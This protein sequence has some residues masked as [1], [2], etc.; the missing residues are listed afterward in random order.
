LLIDYIINKV[1][2]FK[3]NNNISIFFFNIQIT[4]GIMNQKM[5]DE[6]FVQIINQTWKNKNTKTNRK[7]WQLITYCL[8]AFPPSVNL[9]KYLFK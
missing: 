8:S 2:C 4:K 6:I 1:F 3:V 5:R 7:A 9:Y